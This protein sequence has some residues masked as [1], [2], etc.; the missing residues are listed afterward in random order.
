[1]TSPH[2]RPEPP[3][4]NV[5]RRARLAWKSSSD[6]MELVQLTGKDVSMEN[7][8]RATTCFVQEPAKVVSE[9]S[10]PV[11]MKDFDSL[12]FLDNPSG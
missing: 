5:I 4:E 1:M 6:L 2:I 9:S 11:R 7:Q 12:H 8:R 3:K 10:W